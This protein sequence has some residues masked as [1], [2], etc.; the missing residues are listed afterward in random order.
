[1]SYVDSDR[2]KTS[3]SF[4]GE[5]DLMRKLIV[6]EFLSLD[7]VMQG[8]GSPDEDREGGFA[9]GG[10]QIPYFDE[11]FAEVA[12][13]GIAE[14]G[15]YLFGRKT[16]EIMA[17]FWPSQPD[18]DMFAATLNGLPKYVASTTLSEPL[19][20]KNSSL[21]KGDV[22]KAVAEL[23]EQDGKN[24]VVLGSGELVQTLMENDLVD[25]FGLMIHPIVLGA[26]KQLFREGSVKR[27]LRLI[28]ST[29]SSKGVVIASYEPVRS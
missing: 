12:A 5:E 9:H 4:I 21:L 16:Y 18:D 20:W 25:E 6:N 22:A 2:L 1:M 14:A 13:E 23:K 19:E 10:W 17:A 29:T 7:G 3:G 11:V 15:G 27:P 24:L 26:G 28:R 8:P